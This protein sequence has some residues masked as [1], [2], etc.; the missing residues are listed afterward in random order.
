M[1]IV[2][3][4]RLQDNELAEK[5]RNLSESQRTEESQLAQEI[6]QYNLMLEDERQKENVL[7]EYQNDLATLL[8]DHES[9]S[10]NSRDTWWF[11]LQM[12]TGTALR[13]LDPARRTIL[14]QTL[15]EADLLDVKVAKQDALLYTA[16]LSGVQF[17]RSISD[18]DIIRYYGI[19]KALIIPGADLRYASFYNVFLS[20]T[21]SFAYSNLDYTDW[22]F[23]EITNVFFKDDMTMNEAKFYGSLIYDTHFDGYRSLDINYHRKIKMNRVSFEYNDAWYTLSI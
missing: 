4:K 22:S 1:K 2:N 6:H 10:N 7:F 20:N 21:P 13:Q 12:E 11:V 16:N 5:Q 9:K 15:L 19:N 3:D 23:S 14:V 17:S 8:L 18:T